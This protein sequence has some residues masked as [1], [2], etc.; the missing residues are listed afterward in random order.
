[1]AW[2]SRSHACHRARRAAPG[3]CITHAVGTT[4][5]TCS[6]FLRN[7]AGLL[8][9]AKGSQGCGTLGK[10]VTLA[11]NNSLLKLNEAM[12]IKPRGPKSTGSLLPLVHPASRRLMSMARLHSVRSQCSLRKLLMIVA[13]TNPTPA[14]FCSG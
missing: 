2:C 1:M 9:C 7:D 10:M 14:G 11:R 5:K 8:R 12:A 3:H 6:G 13:K 4:T